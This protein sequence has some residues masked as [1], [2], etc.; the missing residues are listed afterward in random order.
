M[1]S[2]ARL[3]VRA[4]LSGLLTLLAFVLATAAQT[5]QERSQ[6]TEE[7]RAFTIRGKLVRPDGKPVAD[8]RVYCFLMKDGM[9][10]VQLGMVEEK[11]VPVNPNSKTDKQ[12]QFE[13]KVEPAFINKHLELTREYTVGVYTN[14]KAIPLPI[15]KLGHPGFFDLDLVR[16]AN[17]VV[18]LNDVGPLVLKV[19]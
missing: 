3:L 7:V 9:A 14:G 19:D 5:E 10:L 17:Y 2:L 18:N 8:E 4:G 12:G 16:E 11:L 6:S 15:E 13:I 1:K